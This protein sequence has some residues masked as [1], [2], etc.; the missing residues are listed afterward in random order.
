MALQLP[1]WVAAHK[2]EAA[3]GALVAVAGG[4]AYWKKRKAAAGASSSSAAT[5]APTTGGAIYDANGNLIAGAGTTGSGAY[6]SSA[7][8]VYNSL[9]GVLEQ[10][11]T[12]AAQ[13]GTT[14]PISQSV[15]VS[16]P[17]QVDGRI[18]T[19]TYSPVPP[20]AA[21]GIP[22][23]DGGVTSF[24]T[25]ILGQGT[26]PATPVAAAAA[27][28]TTATA[29]AAP[30]YV[31]VANPT[32]LK[33]LPAGTNLYADV[34]GVETYLTPAAFHALKPGTPIQVRK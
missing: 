15:P 17:I 4:V 5:V 23:V 34:N 33:A 18:N 14:N 8:D 29:P 2:P 1:P 31:T 6:D 11:Q 7:N 32:A 20:S 9:Q 3:A 26:L 24:G 25:T 28:T 10:L 16:T 30:S 22:G 19:G 12:T 13:M 21:A 27:P